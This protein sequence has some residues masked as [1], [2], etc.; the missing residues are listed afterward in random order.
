MSRELDRSM[1]LTGGAIKPDESTKEA[2]VR[3]FLEETNFNVQVDGLT[4]IIKIFFSQLNDLPTAQIC[5]SGIAHP[6]K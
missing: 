4:A 1:I 2:V 5:L 6:R 3:E